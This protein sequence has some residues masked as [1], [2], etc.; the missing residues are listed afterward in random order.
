[1]LRFTTASCILEGLSCQCR[2]LLGLGGEGTLG[3][4]CFYYDFPRDLILLVLRA[5]YLGDRHLVCP[6]VLFLCS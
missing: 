1:M 3:L 6:G 5:G 2:L 4:H